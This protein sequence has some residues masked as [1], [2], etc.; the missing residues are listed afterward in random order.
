MRIREIRGKN[1]QKG[2]PNKAEENFKTLFKIFYATD[3][4][5]PGAVPGADLT[6]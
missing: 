6:L 5:T 1:C 4:Y 2:K 3:T